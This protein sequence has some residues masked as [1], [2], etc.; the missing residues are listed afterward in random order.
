VKIVFI[1]ISFC[2]NKEINIGCTLQ[3]SASTLYMASKRMPTSLCVI[4]WKAWRNPTWH[5]TKTSSMCFVY[6][7]FEEIGS[8]DKNLMLFQCFYCSHFLL[9]SCRLSCLTD[10]VII[11]A[12]TFRWC[13]LRT[14]TNCTEM[15]RVKNEYKLYWHVSKMECN[16]MYPEPVFVNI[17][18]DPNQASIQ[19]MYYFPIFH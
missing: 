10:F 18:S 4:F 9:E 1:N 19:T 6:L 3:S 2:L 16:C 7:M 8:V 15:M 14:S 17:F 13:V 11:N 12:D 5:A